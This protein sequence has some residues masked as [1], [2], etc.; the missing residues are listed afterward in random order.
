MK[1][2]YKLTVYNH[3][4]ISIFLLLIMRC[5]YIMEI[6][7]SYEYFLYLD[8][9]FNQLIEILKGLYCRT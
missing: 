7:L 4:T 8:N 5:Q 9:K 6:H 1:P 3:P 2:F